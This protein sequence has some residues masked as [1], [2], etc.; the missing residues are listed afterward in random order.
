[1]IRNLKN[2]KIFPS[3]A[4]CGL[5]SLTLQDLL[6]HDEGQLLLV[7]SHDYDF[8]FYHKKAQGLVSEREISEL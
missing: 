5:S 3:S 7:T 2:I 6:S 4:Y 1:M 8:V